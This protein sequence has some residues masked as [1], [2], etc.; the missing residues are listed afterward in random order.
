[1]KY[2]GS[3][4]RIAKEILPVILK[5]RK[6]SQAYIE[7]FVGG[8][9]MIEHVSGVR[10]GNDNNKYLISMWIALQ[11]GWIPPIEVSK[12]DYQK[13]LDNKDAHLDSFIGWCGFNCSYSGKFLSGYAGKTKTKMGTVRDYQAEAHRNISKQLPNLQGVKFTYGSYLELEIPPESIIYCDPPYAGTSKYKTGDFDH[14][15]FWKWCDEQVSKGH[16]V[17]V[18][19]YNAPEDWKCIWQ[20]E[21]KSSLSAN[22]KQGGSKVSIEK[23]FTK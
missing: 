9:N 4:S 17:F 20:K 10:I 15:S 13:V 11:N 6:E 22:G 23:L 2:M 14:D 5:D 16:K 21:M 19:E 12:E 8:A 3:K 18:S 1:M 7:P